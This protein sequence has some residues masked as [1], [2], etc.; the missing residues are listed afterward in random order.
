MTK[1]SKEELQKSSIDA[2][3]MIAID[4]GGQSEAVWKKATQELYPDA[5]PQEVEVIYSK[6]FETALKLLDSLRNQMPVE[7]KSKPGLAAIGTHNGVR[8]SK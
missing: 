8:H 2:L 3:M 4:A 1:L 6:L 7:K 5:T